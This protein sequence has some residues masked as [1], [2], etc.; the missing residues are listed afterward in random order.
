M[1]KNYFKTALRNLRR[2]KIYAAINIGGIA[3]G[4]AAF[5]L[6][7]LYVSDELSY[8]RSFE[9]ANRIC[10]IVQHA[11]WQ[12]GSMNIV[13]TAPP[14]ANAFKNNFP[15]VEDAARIDLEGGGV[16]R[17]GD[18]IIKQD[19][20]CVADNTLFK[21][22]NYHFLYGDGTT[23][24]AQPQSIVITESLANKIF[25]DAS[26]A[27]NQTILFGSDNYPNK[28]TGV[29]N[30]MPQNSHLQFSGIRSFDEELSNDNWGNS[31]LYTYLLLKKG[32]D[33]KS[34]EKKLP[35]LN[36]MIMAQAKY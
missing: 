32:A 17:Y 36:K 20:I 29:I 21:L 28:V 25:G 27:I 8:D 22:F 23:A 10:R 15:E 2:N 18:K 19:D 11:S 35:S 4:L 6:I 16:I 5:W 31:Y 26:K 14:F 1:L 34:L 12:G 33:I 7:V 9:N 3:I 13:P 30:D 24:L